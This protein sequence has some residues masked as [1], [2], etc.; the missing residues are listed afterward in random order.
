MN[1][2]APKTSKRGLIASTESPLPPATNRWPLFS[3]SLRENERDR[4]SH[5]AFRGDASS[6]IVLGIRTGWYLT[7][8]ASETS[9]TTNKTW[10]K[11]KR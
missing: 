8:R 3:M 4:I 7:V 6:R 5:S 9:H 10:P 11:L 2:S 1:S